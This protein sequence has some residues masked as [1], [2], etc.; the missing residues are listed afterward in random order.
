[1]L[2]PE[3]PA[4]SGFYAKTCKKT[5][6]LDFKPF[7]STCCLGARFLWTFIFSI[8]WKDMS[9]QLAINCGKLLWLG[10]RNPLMP[11]CSSLSALTTRVVG[12]MNAPDRRGKAASRPETGGTPKD[13][14]SSSCFQVGVVFLPKFCNKIAIIYC[15][16]WSTYEA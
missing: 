3:T 4:Q 5:R 9:L 6:N 1:M 7:L 13:S 14:G 8:W 15:A 2:H 10:G 12:R 11:S 16:P